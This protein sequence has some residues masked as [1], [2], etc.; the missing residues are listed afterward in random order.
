MEFNFIATVIGLVIL[1][2]VVEKVSNKMLS[3]EKIRLSET[4]GKRINRG[5]QFVLFVIFLILLWFM[6]DVSDSL[7]MYYFLINL[8]LIYGYQSVMEFIFIKNSKQ[9][10][11]T[12]I[13]L[14]II[15]LCL[16][17][18]YFVEVIG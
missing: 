14:I 15:S 8:V 4:P 17:G 16:V 6:T 12:T 2:I 10:L 13:L 1:L 18:W 11:S 7:R 9:Y 3:V 5:G